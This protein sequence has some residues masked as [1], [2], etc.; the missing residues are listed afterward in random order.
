MTKVTIQGIEFDIPK[1][2]HIYNVITGEEEKRP[3]IISSSINKEQVWT[4]TELPE[5]YEYKRNEEISKQDEDKDYFDVEL[6]NFRSQEWDRRL[7][8]VW[9]MNNGVA[10]YI[11][12]LP[13][14][15]LIGGKL[16]LASQNLEK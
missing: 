5:N 11:T 6:E 15:F 9:F 12:G 2:G 1:K 14:F 7:N 13:I 16:I 10:E 8:G 4:R 3:V